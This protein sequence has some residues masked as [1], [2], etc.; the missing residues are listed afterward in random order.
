MRRNPAKGEVALVS[1]ACGV[2][3]FLTVFLAVP[4][5]PSPCPDPVWM[6]LDLLVP[7]ALA[8]LLAGRLRP[9][10]APWLWL[11]LPVQYILLFLFRTPISR[12]LGIHLE[13]LGGFEYLFTAAVWPALVTLIQFLTLLLL[14]KAARFRT[15]R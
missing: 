3:S 9:I 8:L 14:Q 2:L 5:L 6:A 13:G 11:G 1:A 7:T 12:G 15:L 4:G 10:P